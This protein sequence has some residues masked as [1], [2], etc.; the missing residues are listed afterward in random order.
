[1]RIS[2]KLIAVLVS[3]V[4]ISLAGLSFLIEFQNSSLPDEFQEFE[5]IE[6]MDTVKIYQNNY[7]IPHIIAN[8]ENDLFFAIG[9]F[10]AQ[11][12]MWQMDYMRRKAAGRLSEIFGESSVA[13]DRLAHALE[14]N[15]TAQQNFKK[16]SKQSRKILEDYSRGVNYFIENNPNKLSFEFGA[17]DYKPEKWHP[18]D[19]I[20]INRLFAIELSKSFT[21]DVTLGEIAE[22]LGKEKAMSL[23]SESYSSSI[24]DQGDA[25]LPSVT[26]TDTTTI[27]TGANQLFNNFTKSLTQ[28]T[29]FSKSGS[30]LG[31]NTWATKRVSGKHHSAV[32]ACDPHLSLG[33]PGN[34]LQMHVTTA[35]MNII[36]ACLPGIP[37]FLTGRNDY[38]SWGLASMMADDCDF[39]IN[40]IDVK[41]TNYYSQD[42]VKHKIKF[43]KDT[44]K[45]KNQVEQIYYLK[46]IDDA[47]VI[48]EAHSANQYY[49]KPGNT[50]I[51]FKN[52]YLTNTA[53]TYK[54][55]GKLESD[56]VL[57][58]YKICK[59]KSWSEFNNGT[60][61]WAVPAVNFSYADKNGNYGLTPAGVL[62]IR[63]AQCNPL[64]PSDY[65]SGATWTGFYNCSQ[66]PKLL[67]PSKMY[68]AAANSKLADNNPV[69]ISKYYEPFSRT[70]RIR[71]MLL[72]TSNYNVRDAQYMQN[73]YLSAYARTN[74]KAILPIF[75]QY[76]YLFD[77][78]ERTAFSYLKNWDFISTPSSVATTI[79]NVFLERCFYNTFRDELGSR[80]YNQYVFTSSLPLNK[81]LEICNNSNDAWFDNVQTPEREKRDYII[82]KSFKDALKLLNERFNYQS[83]KK[84]YW[85]EIHTITL[86]H[87]LSSYKFVEPSVTYGPFKIG[88]NSTT[89]NSSEYNFMTPY[90]TKSGASVRFIADMSTDFVYTSMPGGTSGD[91][92]SNNFKNQ[93]QLWLNGGYIPIP[94]YK[95]P[96][97]NY[98][99][100][101]LLQPE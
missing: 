95:T 54:W 91:P 37:L 90:Q 22:R 64:L 1:M 78:R 72:V 60:A 38:I 25:G 12:R 69:Y 56:E 99:L 59:A 13:S 97:P 82:I 17:L 27:S 14:I 26:P 100:R 51:P 101:I 67:N 36:G 74:M 24:L 52:K 93:V 89:I 85:G 63:N 34:W 9:Y 40:K 86:S 73:D 77:K 53:L 30:A 48:S 19:C 50:Y 76:F 41:G 43:L 44:I 71:E 3:L 61:L 2:G 75:N 8:S 42:S 47:P 65:S 21:I 5:S 68:V 55:T 83:I 80:L 88:G 58:M 94:I 39:F 16:I 18:E 49:Y 35:T 7:G 98:T 57:A 4:V 11:E 62:P 28:A 66:M 45:I 33:L 96:A 32:L 10:H 29:H 46:M 84:W 92:M 87:P 70:E 6:L 20:M 23:V 15:K 81:F 79:Y 31:S